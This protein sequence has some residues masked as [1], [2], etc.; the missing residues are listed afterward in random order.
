[1][2]W[3]LTISSIPMEQAIEET[4]KRALAKVI[5]VGDGKRAFGE[6]GAGDARRQG[7]RLAE[8]TS[9]GPTQRV[10]PVA[11][12]WKELADELEARSAEAVADLDPETIVTYAQRLWIIPPPTSQLAWKSPAPPPNPAE[13]QISPNNLAFDAARRLSPGALRL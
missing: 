6:V 8:L 1:M 13:W 11:R 4:A 12:G 3:L 5:P 2:R 9:F 10:R 7:E